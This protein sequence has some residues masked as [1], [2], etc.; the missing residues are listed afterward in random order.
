[1]DSVRCK[2]I[3]KKKS[4]LWVIRVAKVGQLAKKLE[5]KPEKNFGANI[6]GNP[7]EECNVFMTR[8]GK[9]KEKEKQFGQFMEIFK[10]L[11][12]TV[13]LTET[14]Q[15]IPAYAKHLKQFLSKK[16]KYLDEET[17]EVQ[18]NCSAIMQKN[19]PPK[20]K[21]L[22]SFNIP[23]IIGNHDIGKTLV[24]LG[25]SINLMPLSMLKKIG[26]LKVKPTRMIL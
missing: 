9:M 14:L 19:L 20:F 21:D 10:Q 18:G 5:E 15:Q 26:G 8:S 24:D 2:P 3:P 25:V 12:I 7:K 11:E 17:I 16:K 22:G 1:M 6:D 13:P 23:C 4:I